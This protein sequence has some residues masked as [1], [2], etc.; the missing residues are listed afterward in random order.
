M[1]YSNQ[2]ILGNI[3]ANLETKTPFYSIRN[4]MGKENFLTMQLHQRSLYS[5]GAFSSSVPSFE[6][7]NLQS[8]TYTKNLNQEK[9]IA[10]HVLDV[11]GPKGKGGMIASFDLETLGGFGPTSYGKPVSDYEKGLS[12]ITEFAVH[13]QFMAENGQPLSDT[14]RKNY[15][16]GI[17]KWQEDYYEQLFKR[18]QFLGMENL[19]STEKSTLERLSRYAGDQVFI[20][21]ADTRIFEVNKLSDSTISVE[22][23][24]EGYFNL[25]KIGDKQGLSTK[26]GQELYKTA[27]QTL[28][29]SSVISGYNINV[30]DIPVLNEMSDR[31]GLAKLAPKEHQVYD[32]MQSIRNAFQGMGYQEI[33]KIGEHFGIKDFNPSRPGSL[34]AFAEAMGV[35]ISAHYA[36]SDVDATM[37]VGFFK[38]SFGTDF[39]LT[40]PEFVRQRMD[41]L[42]PVKS[43]I[44]TNQDN[45]KNR[46][47]YANKSLMASN[48]SL[49]FFT[50]DGKIQTNE[51]VINRGEYYKMQN[52]R[53]ITKDELVRQTDAETAVKILSSQGAEDGIYEMVLSGA[54]KHNQQKAVHLYRAK[55]EDYQ[56]LYQ[57]HLS[58]KNVIKSS[59]SVTSAYDVTQG[60][61]DTTTKQAYK[62]KAR[63]E[64]LSYIDG[65]GSKSFEHMQ[66]MYEAYNKTEKTFAQKGHQLTIDNVRKMLNGTLEG[67]SRDEIFSHFNYSVS[68][69][70]YTM[71]ENMFGLMK[72]SNK[73]MQEVFK[74]INETITLEAVKANLPETW[75]GT[76]NKVLESA[77][78]VAFTNFMAQYEFEGVSKPLRESQLTK[79]HLPTFDSKGRLAENLTEVDFSSVQNATRGINRLVSGVDKF[80]PGSLQHARQVEALKYIA[81]TLEQQGLLKQ[82]FSTTIKSNAQVFNVA[83]GMAEEI[84]TNIQQ[85]VN[86]KDLGLVSQIA[87]N[88]GITVDFENLIEE[89]STGT[90]K[91]L[92]KEEQAFAIG[93]LRNIQANNQESF[94]MNSLKVKL[95]TPLKETKQFLMGAGMD[96]YNTSNQLD[97]ASLVNQAIV[98]S[99][100]S[101]AVQAKGRSSMGVIGDI[102]QDK[103][104]YTEQNVQSLT[105]VLF[106]PRHGFVGKHGLD[107]R[108]F[109]QDG[110]LYMSAAEQTKGRR[111]ARMIESGASIEELR[112]VGIITKLPT[113]NNETGVRTVKMGSVHKGIVQNMNVFVD[114]KRLDANQPI[115]KAF[116]VTKEDT[117][118]QMIKSIWR[119]ESRAM[120][121]FF[122]GDLETANRIITNEANK[123]PMKAPSLTGRQTVTKNGQKITTTIANGNDRLINDLINYRKIYDLLPYLYQNDETVR[124][125]VNQIY[126]KQERISEEQVAGKMAHWL[127]TLKEGGSRATDSTDNIGL[128][129]YVMKNT[130]KGDKLIE[131]LIQ[132]GAKDFDE[133]SIK[134]LQWFISSNEFTQVLAEGKTQS[135]YASSS[136]PIARVP[137]GKISDSSR[138]NQNAGLNYQALDK[139]RVT[140]NYQPYYDRFNITFGKD[141][142]TDADLNDLINH[143]QK[144]NNAYKNYVGQ[145]SGS[146]KMIST[147]EAYGKIDA[148]DK[149]A[150]LASLK[151]SGHN[152]SQEDLE[153]AINVIRFNVNTHE[154]RI[155]M[156]PILTPLMNEPEL[157]GIKAKDLSADEIK[158]Y[159][160]KNQGQKVKANQKIMINGKE[161]KYD[162]NLSSRL[163]G[164]DGNT[165]FFEPLQRQT[166]SVKVS[167]GF[168]EKGMASLIDFGSE[169]ENERMIG[170]TSEL[171][172]QLFGKTA[173]I[174]N[175]EM[176]KHEATGLISGRYIFEAARS[177]RGDAELE[178]TFI[179]LMNKHLPGWGGEFKEVD[180]VRSFIISGAPTK[181]SG[182]VKGI[183]RLVKELGVLAKDDERLTSVF[184]NLQNMFKNDEFRTTLA[185]TVSSEIDQANQ[186]KIQMRVKQQFGSEQVQGF[187]FLQGKKYKRW[188][189]FLNQFEDGMLHQTDKYQEGMSYVRGIRGT[190]QG[191]QGAEINP[192]TAIPFEALAVPRGGISAADMSK[193]FFDVAGAEKYISDNQHL[194]QIKK[195]DY[196]KIDLGN[197][198]VKNPFT[199][200]LQ[201]FIYL[202]K[203]TTHEVDGIVHLSPS[204]KRTAD[205]LTAIESLKNQNSSLSYVAANRRVNEAY[206]RLAASFYDE[207]TTKDGIVNQMVL[208]GRIPLT[209][210][211][212]GESIA[213]PVLTGM[214]GTDKETAKKVVNEAVEQIEKTGDLSGIDFYDKDAYALGKSLK[215]GQNGKLQIY[216]TAITSRYVLEQM[217]V[218]FKGIGRQL[219]NDEDVLST[220]ERTRLY[221]RLNKEGLLSED[222]KI[223]VDTSAEA[224]NF[225][226]MEVNQ[227]ELDHRREVMYKKEIRKRAKAKKKPTFDEAYFEVLKEIKGKTGRQQ[228]SEFQLERA[229]AIANERMKQVP[230][231]SQEELEEAKRVAYEIADNQVMKKTQTRYDR[232]L[233]RAQKAELERISERLG[234]I[235]AE[236]IGFAGANL[237][238]PAFSTTSKNAAR[239]YLD[240]RLQGNVVRIT[241]TT[242]LK[243]N[244]DTD[245]DKTLINLYLAEGEHGKYVLMNRKDQVMEAFDQLHEAQAKTN[246]TNWIKKALKGQILDEEKTL[247]KKSWENVG[248]EQARFIK[249]LVSSLGIDENGEL[250]DN[251]DFNE[252]TVMR[253]IKNRHNKT[254]IGY[255]SNP[256][257]VIR[258]AAKSIF[259]EAGGENDLE[260]ILHFTNISEQKLIDVKHVRGDGVNEVTPVT[261]Y[262]RGLGLLREAKEEEEYIEG[263]SYIIESFDGPVFKKGT[264]PK[265][266]DIVNGI[267]NSSIELKGDDLKEYRQ[268]EDS[269]FSLVKLFKDEDAID[270][271]KDPFIKSHV[272]KSDSFKIDS[273]KE[274]IHHH[275]ALLDAKAELLSNA[276]DRLRSVLAINSD[277]VLSHDGSRYQTGTYTLGDY[278][279]S[280]N[281]VHSVDFTS[282]KGDTITVY[283]INE[284]DVIKQIQKDFNLHQEANI[285][286][287]EQQAL[288]QF[289]D[290]V[291]DDALNSHTSFV[292]RK[293]ESQ[294]AELLL[295]GDID[296]NNIGESVSD[297]MKQYAPGHSIQDVASITSRVAGR[298]Q[299]ELQVLAGLNQSF[300]S[301]EEGQAVES[302]TKVAERMAERNY[303]TRSQVSEMIHS[304]NEQI[305]E[306][307]LNADRARANALQLGTPSDMDLTN[308]QIKTLVEESQTS[309]FFKR[310]DISPASKNMYNIEDATVYI[311]GMSNVLADGLG[312]LSDLSDVEIRSL[313]NENFTDKAMNYLV[314]Y[315]TNVQ[316][317]TEEMIENVFKSHGAGGLGWLDTRELSNL[318]SA[319]DPSHLESIVELSHEAIVGRGNYA[320]LKLGDLS[321]NDLKGIL[322]DP[323]MRQ[324]GSDI[325]SQTLDQVRMRVHAIERLKEINDSSSVLG[326]VLEVDNHAVGRTM[327]TT[328]DLRKIGISIND[329]NEEIKEAGK[330]RIKKSAASSGADSISHLSGKRMGLIAAGVAVAGITAS[331]IAGVQFTASQ[332]VIQSAGGGSYAN[333]GQNTKRA[334]IGNQAPA[335]QTTYLNQNVNYTISAKNPRKVG[336]HSIG[337][338]A[339]G[340]TGSTNFRVTQRDNRDQLSKRW[341]EQQVIETL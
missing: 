158:D 312:E 198:T 115:E 304:F 242:S 243:L 252:N 28:N 112:E 65:S 56:D 100:E 68:P 226:P 227:T 285:L 283:G 84:Y 134:T 43:A 216:D 299:N 113:V 184:E 105:D 59:Q 25:R 292:S 328:S 337:N 317:T 79:L 140:P 154:Q 51:W 95:K 322:N 166:P 330:A 329:M 248:D 217:N 221:E 273:L 111:V 5:A 255:L 23:A 10:N 223:H 110:Q 338:T 143:H 300:F 233:K 141:V 3:N 265:A 239:V 128:E 222:G 55:V 228:I 104:G 6:F 78:Q 177:V 302:F 77:R 275:S 69:Q 127:Q 282:S 191:M 24:K 323:T 60:M 219:M 164:H 196:L 121:A 254:A 224:I 156:N 53:Y 213:P 188:A 8:F 276:G 339:Y 93:Y 149:N 291:L 298:S 82:G 67:V 212:L 341:I 274:G 231:L 173:A 40:L 1:I 131:R 107:V 49:D 70:R 305:R 174:A 203:I 279:V 96:A 12:A 157:I 170:L 30:F 99:M 114:Q 126:M 197:V 147:H 247:R 307:G 333:D 269:L 146:I 253:A 318:T 303:S 50:I 132:V 238:D 103:Y 123:P 29:N 202:P 33:Q 321:V 327:E 309:D 249:A 280:E 9:E 182:N 193:T 260:N 42:E 36:S 160:E 125:S 73:T 331:A 234:L 297:L 245:G 204:Q 45:A 209:A 88:K 7:A 37:D 92:N 109:D 31:F 206:S 277:T 44:T 117:V 17:E 4:G 267:Y 176:G 335:S 246:S 54:S 142:M 236:E 270:I 229:K 98:K 26:K 294:V 244:Q 21:D 168:L 150:V 208:Q 230:K 192:A 332:S 183:E 313:V 281:N 152:Y 268:L 19:S 187:S 163:V 86:A 205:L 316:K 47:F 185:R 71:F 319:T 301:T 94:S 320:G 261:L 106:N 314:N 76:A 336:L 64:F 66:Q 235:Y 22:K 325:A 175:F 240:D 194:N 120:Q 169:S 48:E 116:R 62:D 201:N 129:E 136:N 11:I 180:G 155:L 258:E 199:G 215:V 58:M 195:A 284:A 340:L 293:V 308:A 102:L 165:L 220:E 85:T 46:V 311:N 133:D 148:L 315:N 145:V 14:I 15:S 200:E 214:V 251:L 218:D 159:F 324:E 130:H 108:I 57:S 91:S 162:R 72:S 287:I 271:M 16:F 118:D 190:I 295:K 75:V 172:E 97:V 90:I 178:Q 286:E 27:I 264:A 144:T 153:R 326:Q 151:K 119:S 20:Q 83:Q 52:M 263:M 211:V 139:N 259:G 101:H 296:V 81:E 210:R 189:E 290:N 181:E 310:V 138:A 122:V 35:Q 137:F 167:A 87:T 74:Q 179:S 80:K 241:S 61:I 257:Y 171:W 272:W 18:A 32:V 262:G 237:R 39:S 41:E 266:E 278:K 38:K 225:K 207:F 288:K 232:Q 89:L 13:Q 289:G 250:M 63:R 161:V 34:E 186:G 334:S 124:A 256:N 306:K 135:W 2:Y